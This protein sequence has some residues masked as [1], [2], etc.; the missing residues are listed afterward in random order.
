MKI[1]EMKMP[2]DEKLDELTNFLSQ[3]YSENIL[4]ADNLKHRFDIFYQFKTK[5]LLKYPSK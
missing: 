4:S 2:S 5:F 3:I 1:R